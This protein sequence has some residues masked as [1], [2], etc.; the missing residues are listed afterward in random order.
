M[1]RLKYPEDDGSGEVTEV[2]AQPH[3][4]DLTALLLTEVDLRRRRMVQRGPA[5][6]DDGV[7][8]V[9]RSEVLRVGLFGEASSIEAGG[10]VRCQQIGEAGDVLL[11]DAD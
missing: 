3:A 4:L 10:K 6:V 11:A 7:E 9:L 1:K 5:E 2:L 8:L